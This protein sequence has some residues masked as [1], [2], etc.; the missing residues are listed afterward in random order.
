[1]NIAIIPA[2]GGSRRLPRKNV[3]EFLGIP[4]LGWTITQ[5]L[6]SKKI[7]KVIV[8]TDDEEI[9]SIATHYGAE[10]IRRP[11][12][13]DANDASAVRPIAYTVEKLLQ[14]YGSEFVT[15]LAL[16]PT[17]P[18]NKPDDFDRAINLLVEYRADAIV[19]LR[20]MREVQLYKRIDDVKARLAV[21]SKRFE[22]LGESGGWVVTS[23][24][25]YL[26]NARALASDLD[27]DID[28][29]AE[30]LQKMTYYMPTEVW[31]YSDVDTVEEFE[32]TELLMDHYITKGNGLQPYLDYKEEGIQELF[33]EEP[34]S[35]SFGNAKQIGDK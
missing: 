8:S 27:K 33:E 20:P 22:Y 21:Y 24:Q 18:L 31:Q 3:K 7:Q 29:Q 30:G 2:R 34:I 6:C 16:L 12:W 10:V 14:D 4:L 19:P 11:E 17:S 13:P 23:P 1:M 5:A 15:L 28:N 25:N 26:I 32:F 9:E 35:V